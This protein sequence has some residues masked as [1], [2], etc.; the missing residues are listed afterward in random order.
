MTTH[1]LRAA[2]PW[3]AAGFLLTFCSG[4]GQTYFV[5]VFAGEWQAAF[6]LSNGEFGMLYTAATLASAAALTRV[7]KLADRVPIQWLGAGVFAALALAAVV[8]ANAP[9]VLWL[10]IAL[11][12]LRLFGQGLS[13]HTAMTA[14]GRWFNRQRGRAVAI[15]AIGIPAS[16]ALMP[17]LAVAGMSALGWRATWAC[18]ALLLAAIAVPL[19]LLLLRHERHPT[20]GPAAAAVDDDDQRHWTRD[21]VLGSGLFYA[22]MPAVLAPPFVITAIFFNQVALVELRGWPLAWF[23]GWFPLL[24]AVY[25]GASLLAGEVL[26][27]VGAGRLLPWF[28]LPLGLAAVLLG[29]ADTPAILPVAVAGVG[30]TQGFGSTVLGALWPELFGT[31]HLGAIRSLVASV[32]VF[33]SAIAPGLSGVLLD[34]GVGLDTQLLAMAAYCIVVSF[35]MHAVAPR[36]DALR[37]AT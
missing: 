4:F 26:D 9:S 27:R 29:G 13:T 31:R 3:L 14:M 25:V 32:V 2:A 33:A 7:G 18:S 37:Q 21:E 28:L 15:A 20:R 11:F 1:D 36:L 6:G 16:Q 24:A 30:L 10:G 12:A 22:L 5:A 19:L 35:A 17:P 23:T 8:A 34:R